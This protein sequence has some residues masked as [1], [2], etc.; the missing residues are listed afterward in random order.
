VAR[1][2]P[3]SADETRLPVHLYDE[4]PLYQKVILDIAFLVLYHKAVPQ[5][6]TEKHLVR[7][8][9]NVAADLKKI[10]QL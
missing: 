3:E 4:V 10:G 6:R 1:I 7:L 5:V 9:A 8:L 2:Y